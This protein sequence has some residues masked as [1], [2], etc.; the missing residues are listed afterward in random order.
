MVRAYPQFTLR[1]TGNERSSN[2]LRSELERHSVL[3]ERV[4]NQSV[5]TELLVS[6]F[7]SVVVVVVEG[8]GGWGGIC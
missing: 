2:I 5:F 4:E 8:G 1:D 3:W 6:L 7:M